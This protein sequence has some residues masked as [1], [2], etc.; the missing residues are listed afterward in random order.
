MRLHLCAALAGLS[1]VLPTATSAWWDEGHMQ[2]AA[3]AYDRLTPAVRAKVDQLIRLNPQ[4]PSWVAGTPEALKAQY[5]FVRAST[6]A[7]DIK[8]VSSGYTDDS[9]NGPNAGRNIGYHDH[10]MHKYWHFEDIPFSEDAAPVEAPDPVNALTQIKLLTSGLAVSSGLPDDVRSYDLVW[11]IHLVGDAHQPLHATSRFSQ[12][13]PDGDQGGNKESVQ[14]AGG[15]KMLLHA[16]WDSLLGS[17]ST[18]E[19]AIFDAMTDKDTRLPDPD[20]AKAAD[21]DPAHW[22]RDSEQLAEQ[23]A[24]AEPVKTG[25]QPYVLDRT[26]ETNARNTARTQAALAA[27]RLANLINN[28]LK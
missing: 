23:V 16:Y 1:L 2:I 10:L 26:Y 27:A 8:K 19:G 17:S 13:T 5:A 7:D 21:A 24:Y 4:Y 22:F 28:A 14:P 18:P 20:P 12:A 9:V 11:L 6:W 25:T 15:Q 3:V